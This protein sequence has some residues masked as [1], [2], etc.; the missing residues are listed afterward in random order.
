MSWFKLL[1]VNLILIFEL[2]IH[3]SIG[4][5]IWFAVIGRLI[6]SFYRAL[7]FHSTVASV[8]SADIGE[9]LKIGWNITKFCDPWLIKLL[10]SYACNFSILSCWPF[11]SFW[12]NTCFVLFEVICFFKFIIKISLSY[13]ISNIGFSC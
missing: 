6:F 9:V 7:D 5:R 10:E 3:T 1:P 2:F 11:N 4:E 13:E 8:R 12:I